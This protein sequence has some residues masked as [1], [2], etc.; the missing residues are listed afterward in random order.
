[1]KYETKNPQFLCARCG[2][3]KEQHYHGKG[4]CERT[5]AYNAACFCKRFRAK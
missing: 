2:H 4:M 1:V 5:G 3:I